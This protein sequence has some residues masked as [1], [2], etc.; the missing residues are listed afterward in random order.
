M[1]A[2]SLNELK[3]ELVHLDINA[4]RELCMRLA[5]YKKENKELLTYLLFDAHDEQAYIETVKTEIEAQFTELPESNLYLIKKS[6]R[7]ILRIANKQIKYSGVKRTEV[8]LRIFFCS[9][10]KMKRIRMDAGTVLYN[11]YQQ[12]RKKIDQALAALPE[13]LQFDYQHELEVL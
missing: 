1:K 7:K 5:K 6:I 13:D 9:Q 2:A 12:Q 10:I 3:K 4:V 11:L 8:E